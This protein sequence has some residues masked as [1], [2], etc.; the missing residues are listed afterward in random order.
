MKRWLLGAL[1]LVTASLAA[2]LYF[3]TRSSPAAPLRTAPVSDTAAAT[4]AAESCVLPTSGSSTRTGA[5]LARAFRG[6]PVIVTFID[7]LCRNY[8]PLE[9]KQLNEA[10]R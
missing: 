4:W 9:A 7:P 8:C 3:A 5:G 2:A 1:V 10:V 6:R